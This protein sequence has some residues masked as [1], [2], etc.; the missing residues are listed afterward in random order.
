MLQKRV[1]KADIEL[2][3]KMISS[4]IFFIEKMWNLTPQP[5]TCKEL[6]THTR[7]CYGTF[8]RGKHITWQQHQI[9]LGVER[10]LRGEAPKRISVV[11]GHGIGKDGMLSW[12]IHWFLFTRLNA[13]VGCTAPTSDQMYDVLWKEL[14]IWHQRLREGIREKFEW[15]TTHFKIKERPETWWARARTA[16]PEAPEAFAGLHGD[17]VMLVGDE[18]SGI[19]DQIFRTGEGALTNRDVLV[20]LVSNGTRVEGYFYDTH[21]K[22]KENWQNYSFSSEDSPIVERGYPERIAAKYGKDSDEYRYM[23]AGLFPRVGSM[24]EGG[25]LPLVSESQLKFVEDVG[26]LQSPRLGVDPS[27]SGDNKTA[28]VLR[29]P[30]RA[31]VASLK[32][33]S[34][35][36]SIAEDVLTLMTE[37]D[38]DPTKVAVDNFGEGANVPVEIAI[39][40][41]DRVNGINGG[42][43][44]DDPERFLN[45]RAENYWRLREWIV[46][47]GEL[48]T[49]PEWKQILTIRYKRNLK[50]RIVIMSKEDMKLKHGWESPDVADG[51]SLTFDGD[52][53]VSKKERPEQ[54]SPSEIAR[55][56]HGR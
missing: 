34:T 43:M 21:H 30:F 52:R 28:L 16:R 1:S 20:I 50:G 48:V 32:D 40:D 38:I 47:G 49:S 42:D 46:A 10:A 5:L 17:Y 31:K 39:V 19:H 14:S 44:A 37:Y 26:R 2:V 3:R 8:E 29:D 12:L 4:P 35:P 27:G 24:E 15:S 54:L 23:V 11:S 22:D 56:V 6:H 13:Q 36:K 53:S 9:L 25:W 41:G 7:T 18:A 51:L 33:K 45:K 55:I